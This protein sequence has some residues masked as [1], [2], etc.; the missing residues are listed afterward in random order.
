M[1]RLEVISRFILAL[2]ATLLLF[3]SGIGLPPLGVILMPFV[4]Q[5]VL[6]FGIKF[7]IGWGVGVVIAAIVFV[8]LVAGVE[9]ALVYAI[10]ALIAGLVMGLLG[11]VRAIEFLVF[12]VA[13]VV[14]TATAALLFYSFGSWS[15]MFEELRQGLTH[16]LA[17]AVRLHEKMGLPQDSLD[18]LKERTP[19]II[20]M[21]VQ[22]IPALLFLSLA[23]VALI[24]ILFL[25]RRFPQR[26]GQ[27]LSV[28]N[29]REWKGPEFLVWGLILCGFALFIPGLEFVRTVS[30]NILIIIG[31]C[32]FAQGLAIIGYFFHKN[33]VP[34][35]LRGVTY[36]LIIFQQIFTLLV[37]GLGLFDL[38]ADFRRLRKNNLTPSQAS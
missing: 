19:Q 26:R 34:R 10:F 35:F 20:E 29:L 6:T 2:A 37:V 21:M 12:G 9:L 7:G 30:V 3:M 18:L 25:C 33:N 31:A 1:Q 17:S 23:L 11:R 8:G 32:Y 4:P 38:W 22:L 36:V 5:P 14:F 24:N 27:W 15:A 16:Q 28:D 13:I